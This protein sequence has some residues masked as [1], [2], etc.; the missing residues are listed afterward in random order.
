MLKIANM[1]VYILKIKQQEKKYIQE[2]FAC[3]ETKSIED[4]EKININGVEAILSNGRSIDW[5]ADNTIYF[6]SGK[7]IMKG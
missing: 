7:N 4:I 2:R 6:I 3:Y 1:L 5:E